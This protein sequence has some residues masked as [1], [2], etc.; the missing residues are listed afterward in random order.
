MVRSSV[1]A[2][3]HCV[4]FSDSR[5][6]APELLSLAEAHDITV[7]ETERSMF[8]ATETLLDAGLSDAAWV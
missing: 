3:V 8:S 6:P 7:M 5:R 2:E 4:V 1:M